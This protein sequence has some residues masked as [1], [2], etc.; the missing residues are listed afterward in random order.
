MWRIEIALIT[1]KIAHI[2]DFNV[3]VGFSNCLTMHVN[4][5]IARFLSEQTDGRTDR[6]N[7]SLNPAAH[8]RGN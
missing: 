4:R 7:Q 1:I 8:A 3:T 5:E 2:V 6:Q